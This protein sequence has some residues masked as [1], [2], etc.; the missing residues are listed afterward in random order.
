[1]GSLREPLVL[2]DDGTL[3]AAE[4]QLVGDW[5]RTR[6]HTY[7]PRCVEPTWIPGANEVHQLLTKGTSTLKRR[8]NSCAVKASAVVWG[9]LGIESVAGRVSSE[10]VRPRQGG[11]SQAHWQWTAMVEGGWL[12]TTGSTSEVQRRERIL[13][14]MYRCVGV[15]GSSGQWVFGPRST[16]HLMQMLRRH[17]RPGTAGMDLLSLDIALLVQQGVFT[18]DCLRRRAGRGVDTAWWG[19]V[20]A[21]ASED[22][23]LISV[24]ALTQLSNTVERWYRD[25]T[26]PSEPSLKRGLTSPRVLWVLDLFSGFRSLDC[27]VQAALQGYCRAGDIVRCIGLDICERLVRGEEV[28]EPD[29]CLDFLDDDSLPAKGVVQRIAS[30]IGLHLGCLVHVH[31]SSPCDT[32]SRADASNRTRF[33][34]YRDWHAPHCDPLS[35]SLTTP[36]HQQLAQ[37]HDKLEQKLFTTLVTESSVF[38]FC[39]GVENPVGAMARKR[40]VGR[41]LDAGKLIRVTVDHCNFA[42]ADEPSY[43]KATDYFTNFPWGAVGHSGDGRCGKSGVRTGKQCQHGYVNAATGRWKHHY[44]IGQKS[45]NEISGPGLHRRS[46]KNH[47]PF[48]ECHEMLLASAAHWYAH[49]RP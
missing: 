31:A 48:H 18:G 3:S 20:L 42:P 4:K 44:T 19:R 32:N 26:S 6:L 21:L 36:E 43:G 38:H 22:S 8:Y 24:R 39:F 40:H 45:T 37:A 5:L 23:S 9:W 17:Y 2:N 15:S 35:T 10:V 47:L 34:G 27:P 11:T 25:S 16:W 49:S 7:H 46:Q 14:C 29:L 30:D 12:P 41:L 13:S 28:I 33:C 1:M